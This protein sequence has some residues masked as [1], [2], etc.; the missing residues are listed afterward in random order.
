MAIVRATR[1]GDFILASPSLRALRGALPDARI[2]LV[3]LPI[4]RDLAERCRF[5]DR[6][7]AFPGYP[8]VAEQYFDARRAAEFFARMQGERFDLAI[9]L[10]GSG[11]CT[12]PFTL[13]LGARYTAG[14]TRPGDPP[15]RLD[16]AFPL[17]DDGPE[18]ERFLAFVEFLGAPATGHEL[19]LHTSSA[20][21]A[22]AA[23]LL[24]TEAPPYVGVQVGARERSKRWA[25]DRFADA[26][27][28]LRRRLGGTIVLIGGPDE[29]AA[30]S[31]VA[32]R[33]GA[34]TLDLTTRV[35]LPEMAAVIRR[36]R[37]LLTNDSAPAHM[38]YAL[39]TPSVTI[40]G[41]TDPARWGPGRSARHL[42]AM[43]AVSCRPCGYDECP[44]GNA[45]LCGVSVEAVVALAERAMA[46]A[47]P[48]LTI[49]NFRGRRV[50]PERA[51]GAPAPSRGPRHPSP[52]P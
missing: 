23:A 5:V 31:R 47:E 30:A 52:R 40:F 9:Q 27:V 12:N 18:S 34:P 38:A 45:C 6:V 21:E 28:A 10:H 13:M 15:G 48:C 24:R 11:V 49:S 35:S 8:G 7:V 2:T 41:G 14:L 43:H 22:A 17:P 20:D 25:L 44:I 26:A 42:V 37:V 50:P 36:L 33:A 39:G 29:H 3:A 46:S 19:E 1:I 16:A 51:T 32:A 4:V